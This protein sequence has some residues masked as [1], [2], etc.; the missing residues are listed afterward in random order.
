MKEKK[1]ITICT[2][3][4]VMAKAEMKNYKF[5]SRSSAKLFIGLRPK[6]N[7]QRCPKQA[8]G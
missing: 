2:L 1:S 3:S 4:N 6:D 8:V 5:T 7:I